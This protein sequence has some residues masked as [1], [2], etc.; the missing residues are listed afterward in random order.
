MKKIIEFLS[1]R[2]W[3]MY[4]LGCMLLKAKLANKEITE[5]EIHNIFRQ[6]FTTPR[7][8]PVIVMP[9]SQ[10]YCTPSQYNI[11]I[12]KKFDAAGTKI[13]LYDEF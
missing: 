6:I 7:I 3:E 12:G 5:E 8:T 9:N 13:Y 1:S 2:E 11:D 4:R 10:I